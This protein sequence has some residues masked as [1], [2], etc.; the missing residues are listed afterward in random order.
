[1]KCAVIS[2]VHANLE[3]LTAVLADIRKTDISEILFLGD[4]VGYGPDPEVCVKI[5]SSECDLL[6][7]GNHDH[8]LVGL[9]SVLSFNP[10]AKAAMEWTRSVIS[11]E[12]VAVLK[13]L[14]F[15]AETPDG[16]MFLAHSSPMEYTQW[17]YLSTPS[18]AALNFG[19]FKN[20]LC[21][22]GH[23]HKPSIFERLPAGDIIVKNTESVFGNENRYIINAGS[24][25][26]P[27]DGD[28]RACYAV[29]DDD[30]VRLRRVEYEIRLTQ[31][32]MARLGLPGQLIDRLSR[33]V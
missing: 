15:I 5:L 26:Q 11:A 12:T 16:R 9:T 31:E 23:S 24:V 2:D 27:R 30:S 8:A 17:H 32:K 28:P 29:L 14:P 4:A 22:V 10:Y 18:D 6:I 21:F 13:R 1:M 25:G 3:A 7:A 20:R 19:F 33:G